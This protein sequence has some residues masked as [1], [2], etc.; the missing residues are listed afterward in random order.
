[1]MRAYEAL[2]VANDFSI[3]LMADLDRDVL[4]DIGI[5]KLA[6]RFAF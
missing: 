3:D 4:K 6:T 5:T 1:M 2:L